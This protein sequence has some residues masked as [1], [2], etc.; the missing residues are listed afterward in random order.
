[1][2]SYVGG[3]LG[4]NMRWGTYAGVLRSLFPLRF[5]AYW[6]KEGLRTNMPLP[7]GVYTFRK[8]C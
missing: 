5:T 8:H 7:F 4:K 2:Q 6:S 1:M 3:T